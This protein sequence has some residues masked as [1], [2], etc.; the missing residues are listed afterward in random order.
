MTSPV[1]DSM[2][3]SKEC[4]HRMVTDRFVQEYFGMSRSN[5]L[6]PLI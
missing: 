2:R 4:N 5:N 3:R 1:F 6:I